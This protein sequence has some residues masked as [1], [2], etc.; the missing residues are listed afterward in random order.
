M[1]NRE[2]GCIEKPV[3]V[4]EEAHVLSCHQLHIE[5]KEEIKLSLIILKLFQMNRI[6]LFVMGLLIAGLLFVQLK[7]GADITIEYIF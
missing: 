4:I 1:V 2:S 7:D 5:Y 3:E 6:L